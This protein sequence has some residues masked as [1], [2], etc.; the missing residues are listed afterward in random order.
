MSAAFIIFFNDI[1][2]EYPLAFRREKKLRYSY[3]TECRSSIK[4]GKEGNQLTP[5]KEP[6]FKAYIHC[7]PI[8]DTLEKVERSTGTDSRSVVTRAGCWKW[9]TTKP[10]W[11]D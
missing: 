4:K 5:K 11:G 9:P 7:Q 3:P 10:F 1:Q 2:P 8:Y 6:D